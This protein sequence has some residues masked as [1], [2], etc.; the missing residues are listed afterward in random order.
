MPKKPRG[1]CLSCSNETPRSKY[2]YCSNACQIE[3]QYQ[4]YIKKWK[5]GKVNRE[6]KEGRLLAMAGRSNSEVE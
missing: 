1:R 5:A 4:S 2:K 3:Y 6:A